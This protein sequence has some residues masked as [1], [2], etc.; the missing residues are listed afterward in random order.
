MPKAARAAVV[1]ALVL[2]LVSGVSVR[3][4]PIMLLGFSF[5]ALTAAIG[6]FRRRAWSAWGFSGLLVLSMVAIL[7]FA[8]TGQSAGGFLQTAISLIIYAGI[9]GLFFFAGLGLS[10]SGAERGTPIPWILLAL[11][12]SVPF[13]LYRPTAIPTRAMEN[14]FLVGDF[15][16]IDRFSGSH[17][18]FGEV[19]AFHYPLDRSQLFV[20]RVVGLPGDHIH[21]ADGKLYRNGAPVD[22]PYVT[23]K[24]Q[25][26][27]NFPAG[28]DL[29]ALQSTG[30][31]M[32]Q[33]DVVNGDV[34]VPAGKYFVLGD[35][36]DS[37]FD[38]RNFG[39]VPAD[40]IV[41]KPKFIYDSLAPDPAD[42]DMSHPTHPP[43]RRWDRVFKAL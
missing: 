4:G 40:D 21:F 14:T 23:G 18:A 30:R 42:T 29:L 31:G 20:R 9:A 28:V 35:A 22:E 3:S 2:A 12:F 6:I 1:V 41:G 26:A 33:H 25:V 8:V 43:L 34:V 15:L 5:A 39:F 7:F 19:V 24:R 27:A 13:V 16:L 37:S 32:M 11:V 38:S 17:P 36:R 10:L